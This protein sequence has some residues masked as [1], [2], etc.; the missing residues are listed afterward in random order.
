MPSNSGGSSNGFRAS[1]PNWRSS[2][3]PNV[4]DYAWTHSFFDKLVEKGKGPLRNVYGTAL[5]Y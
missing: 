4:D 3:G 5:H 1:A 2:T